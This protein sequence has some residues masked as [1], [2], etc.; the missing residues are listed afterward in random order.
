[1]APIPPTHRPPP[2]TPRPSSHKLLPPSRPWAHPP[3]HPTLP[4]VVPSPLTQ[5]PGDLPRK[6]A[7]QGR[8]ECK[9]AALK[10]L[11]ARPHSRKELKVK[12]VDRGWEP[13]LVRGVLRR[14]Q[15]RQPR[16]PR[17]RRCAA[18]MCVRRGTCERC[19]V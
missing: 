17:R 14:L 7:E 3:T 9:T 1:M 12:L 13:E 10:M 5:C 8:E 4:P 18:C 19:E 15:V 6:L 11:G 2:A 16:A